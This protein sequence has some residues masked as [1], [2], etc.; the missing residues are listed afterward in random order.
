M[1]AKTDTGHLTIS[2]TDLNNSEHPV[3]SDITITATHQNQVYETEIVEYSAET[4][5]ISL[6][7]DSGQIKVDKAGNITSTTTTPRLY[8]RGT[9]IQNAEFT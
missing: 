8:V 5:T 3:T 9:Q 4:P 2:A 1:A 7:N 6:T